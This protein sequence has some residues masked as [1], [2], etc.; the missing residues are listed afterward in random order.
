MRVMYKVYLF[1]QKKHIW[2]YN[3]NIY[4]IYLNVK[5]L[6]YLVQKNTPHEEYPHE[7]LV[8]VISSLF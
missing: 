8:L 7:V 5:I 2:V 4:I 1:M 3:V 6:H